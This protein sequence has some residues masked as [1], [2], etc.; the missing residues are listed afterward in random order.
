M[1]GSESTASNCD[2]CPQAIYT[3][4]DS[5]WLK[6]CLCIRAKEEPFSYHGDSG[7]VLF[8]SDRELRL[9][10]FGIIFGIHKHSYGRIT[11]ASNG[12]PTLLELIIIKLSRNGPQSYYVLV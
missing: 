6:N 11:L 9:R 8:E 3:L 12:K 7:A 10:G 2:Y 4:L 5:L 1:T